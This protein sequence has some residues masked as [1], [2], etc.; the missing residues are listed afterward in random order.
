MSNISNLCSIETHYNLK[1][2]VDLLISLKMRWTVQ[3]V[4]HRFSPFKPFNEIPLKE[5]KDKKRTL[6]RKKT[7][8]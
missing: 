8:A 2:Y 3:I 4:F 7:G 5:L 6:E 1:Y